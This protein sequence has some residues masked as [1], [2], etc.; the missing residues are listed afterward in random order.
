[1]LDRLY[2]Q[3]MAIRTF[4]NDTNDQT[5]P[6]LSNYEWAI[7]DELINILSPLEQA[8]KYMS[9]DKYSSMSLMIAT[10]SGLVIKL[11]IIKIKNSALKEIRDHIIQSLKS[12]FAEIEN[13]E[14]STIASFLDPRI[15]D[16]CFL[17]SDYK[18]SA[19]RTILEK[20]E[21]LNLATKTNCDLNNNIF[22]TSTTNEVSIEDEPSSKRPKFDLWEFVTEQQ[23]GRDVEQSVSLE[24][25]NYLKVMSAT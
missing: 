18:R 10:L 19:A 8:T 6:E 17:N 4:L 11:I 24:L 15:K 3:K 23:E 16:T 25:D 21:V 7:I 5:I 20:L 22:K 2:A 13:N 1:M 9:G 12:R 14:Y